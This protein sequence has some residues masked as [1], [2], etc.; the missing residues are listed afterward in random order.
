MKTLTVIDTFAFFFRAYYALPPLK[1]ND[2]FPTGLLTGFINFIHQLQ[3]LHMTDF[4]VFALDSKSS[5]RKELYPLYKANR[6]EPPQD[7]MMQLEV[8][9]SWIEKMGFKTLTKD[10]FEA[11]DVIATLMRL[12]KEQEI[13]GKMVSSDKDLYQ[14]IDDNKIVLYDWV[15]KK[16]IGQEECVKKFGVEPKYFVDFQALIGDSSD[17][18]PGVPGIGPKTASKII[19]MFHTLEEVYENIEKV[20]TKRIQNLLLENKEKAFLSRELVKLRDDIFENLDLKEFVFE[21]KNYLSALKDEFEKYNMNQ[22]LRWANGNKVKSA[23]KKEIKNDL[24][25]NAILLDTKE[26]LFEV[27]NKIKSSDIVAFDSETTSLNTR[28]AKL[29]GFSFAF[30]L[31]ESF[32]VPIAHNYL[33]VGA[34]VSLNDAK[35]AILKILQAKVVGQNLKFDFEVLQNSLNIKPIIAHADTMILAWLLEPGSKVG[36]DFLAKKFFNYDMKS[37][38][39]TVKKG[40]DFSAV[41]IEKATFYA[42]E[43][44]WMSLMLYNKLIEIF[45][46]AGLK[47]LLNEAKNVE[48]PFINVLIDMESAGIKVD[49]D[50]LKYL[51]EKLSKELKNLSEQIYELAGVQFNIRSTKQLGEIL[52]L[53]LALKGA[54]R[55]KTGYSTNEAVLKSLKNEHEIIE[56]ILSYRER[57]K[58]L[59]TYV[60]PLFK[61]A[62]KDKQNRIYTSFLQ[63]GTATGRLSSK[64]PNLQNIPVRSALGREVRSAFVAKEGFKLL[65]I[66]YSQIEL[67]LLAHFSKDKALLK[68]FEEDKDIHLETAIKL[69]GK[70]EG[71]KKRNFAKSINFGL[72]YGMGSRKLSQ[73]LGISAS[74]AKEI[75]NNYF[76]AFPTVKSYLE[77]IQDE[78]KNRGYVET[79]L[80]RRRIFNYE[81]ANAMGKAAI[82]REAVNTVFQGSAADL[83][84]LSMLEI[85]KFLKE[86]NYEAKML[87]QIHDELIF[88]IKD[89][90]IDSLPKKLVHIMENIYDLEVKLKCSASIGDSWDKLK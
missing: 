73:E 22:A 3:N 2:G 43:D 31:K 51:Q 24:S 26:K 83:I 49:I 39:D 33:G 30:N 20:G 23:P 70:D 48:F 17:N 84:K 4:I 71:P 80:K 61:L 44:A 66:D 36:L 59:S 89:E 63:T 6:P 11:D 15:K 90:L 79:L 8:A 7:L 75:I 65:S 38:S 19:N 10:G 55:T 77:Q 67:R 37:Y 76:A 14:L 46:M 34:Q 16:N 68:A 62:T 78:V 86:E 27:V 41:S 28:E 45:K 42:A 72:L 50:R 52:F 9:I 1:S 18:I 40:E 56:K 85:N 21:D 13:Y 29:V 88:E 64:D 53:K 57:Q 58:I 69:F 12:A 82:L 81:E 74:E 47:E 60:E 87:L 54:K 35:E 5:F 32:Y 25:F